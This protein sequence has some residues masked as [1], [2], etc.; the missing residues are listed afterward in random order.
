MGLEYSENSTLAGRAGKRSVVSDAIGQPIS[1]AETR[2]E[3]AGSSVALTLDANIQQRAEDVLSAGGSRLS[4]KG[5]DCDRDGP[6]YGCDP[7]DG[8]LAAC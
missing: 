2:H 5:L 4:S 8:Q 1:I 6:A 7:R 3:R